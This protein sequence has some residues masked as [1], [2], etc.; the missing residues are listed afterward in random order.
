M[1]SLRSDANSI[2]DAAIRAALPDTA[3]KKALA[4]IVPRLDSEGKL[5]LIQPAR[6]RGRWQK[7]HQTNLEAEL[8]AAR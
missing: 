2:I 1:Y 4:D 6:R 7:L 5:V 3:V 8:P